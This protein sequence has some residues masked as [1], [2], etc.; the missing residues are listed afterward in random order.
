LSAP[1]TQSPFTHFAEHFDHYTAGLARDGVDD[2]EDETLS[3]FLPSV[4]RFGREHLDARRIDREK[5]VPTATLAAAAQLGLFG[6]TTPPAYGGTGFTLKATCRVLEEIATF[7]S[8]SCTTLGLH[9]GLGLRGLVRFGAEELKRRYL[10]DF[11]TGGKIAAFSATEADAGSDIASVR[12]Q[13]I[14]DARTGAITV[15]GTKVYVTNGAIAD[16]F[17]ALV[18]GPGAGSDMKGLS[19][20]LIP[21]D[22]PGVTIGAEEEKLGLR[23]SSTTTVHFDNVVIGGDHVI[24]VAGEALGY[25]Q[26]VLAW[27]RT[28]LSA[29]CLGVARRAYAKAVAHA[30]ARRQFGLPLASFGLVQEKIS[31]MAQRLFL[32]DSLVRTVGQA[33]ALGRDITFESSVCKI[34][35]SEAAGYVCDESMQVHGGAGFIEETGIP[36]TARDVRVSR[37]FEGTNEMLRLHAAYQLLAWKATELEVPPLQGHLHPLLAEAFGRAQAGRATYLHVAQ[38][39]RKRHRLGIMNHQ[40]ALK[41]LSETAMC[42]YAMTAV[43]GLAQSLLERLAGN[44][45]A[46]S[47]TA[48]LCNAIAMEESARLDELLRAAEHPLAYQHAD[49]AAA[50]YRRHA[51]GE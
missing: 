7:D 33:Q 19:L 35:C 47:Q 14:R 13:A 32:M 15:S 5:G 24:G 48:A 26:E 10:P 2:G 18:S 36:L 22:A 28:I 29:G 34:L 8:S 46:A 31:R 25:L 9:N 42:C 3:V 11:A 6:L 45:D 21:R 41:L 39:L 17:T 23:G 38:T 12:T 20:L 27:G 4:R 40:H 44:Q 30:L 49:I 50:E 16:G 1:T 37:I 51:G 43:A